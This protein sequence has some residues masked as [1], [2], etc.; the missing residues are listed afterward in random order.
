MPMPWALWAPWLSRWRS[1][2][3][4]EL[5]PESRVRSHRPR[6]HQCH[7]PEQYHRQSCQILRQRNAMAKCLLRGYYPCSPWIG[8]PL[9]RLILKGQHASQGRGVEWVDNQPS[10]PLGAVSITG[11]LAEFCVGCEAPVSAWE[12]AD[13]RLAIGIWRMDAARSIAL[14]SSGARD[15]RKAV[16]KWD[17]FD[18]VMLPRLSGK[19]QDLFRT[20]L[21]ILAVNCGRK[22]VGEGD[23]ACGSMRGT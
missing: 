23:R 18:L 16:G 4:P 6:R 14:L 12:G 7:T 13:R 22:R 8:Y 17:G 21:C 10:S 2:S 19:G 11:K 9:L 15:D 20:C 3:E 1:A 5:P